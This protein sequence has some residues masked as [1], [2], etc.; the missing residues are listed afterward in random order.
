MYFENMIA[1]ISNSVQG[2]KENAMRVFWSTKQKGNE[3]E[4]MTEKWM[5]RGIDLWDRL[6]ERSSRKRGE[7]VRNDRRKF[8]RVAKRWTLQLKGSMNT[9][10]R[11]GEESSS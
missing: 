6:Y 5:A 2:V 10:H 4:G 8:P 7:E 9:N 3:M 11:S 1:E